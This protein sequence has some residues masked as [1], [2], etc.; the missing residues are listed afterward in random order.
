LNGEYFASFET[1]DAG[2]WAFFQAV[3]R[4]E[5]AYSYLSAGMVSFARWYAPTIMDSPVSGRGS[6]NSWLSRCDGAARALL[7][8]LPSR[9]EA[10]EWQA[11]RG[12]LE[13]GA[14]RGSSSADDPDEG[15]VEDSDDGSSAVPSAARPGYAYSATLGREIPNGDCVQSRRDRLWYRAVAG[16]WQLTQETDSACVERH[17]LSGGGGGDG[18]GG[19]GGTASSSSS[20]AGLL[21]VALGAGAV[22]FLAK[23]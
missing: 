22:W 12:L 20:S 21:I 1:P 5:R 23:R 10:L 8:P 19:G 7:Q 16:R 9:E 13:E 17:P 11:W 15:S 18:G 2:M 14:E 6:F 4:N 3:Q